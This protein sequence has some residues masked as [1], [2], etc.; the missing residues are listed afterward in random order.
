MIAYDTRL[1][2][3]TFSEA[4]L[5]KLIGNEVV[6][7]FG[8]AGMVANTSR[9][10]VFNKFSKEEKIETGIKVIGKDDKLSVELH[11]VVVF[12]MNISAIAQS[13]TEKVKYIV[14]QATGMDVDKVT[15]KVDG[16]KE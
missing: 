16:I 2:K 14:K 11:I 13:I 4:F 15:V 1:G 10:K 8:V 5:S 7:C 3:V 6:S 12:G 9:Q